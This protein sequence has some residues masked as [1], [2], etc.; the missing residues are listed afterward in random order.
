MSQDSVWKE[1]IEQYFEDFLLFFFPNIHQD[2]DLERGYQF[3]DKELAEIIG[4]AE[5][6]FSS[7]V[8]S[9]SVKLR[10]EN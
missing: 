2:V 4:E 3:L 8:F 9:L 5:S 6:V 7:P 1:A 10:T